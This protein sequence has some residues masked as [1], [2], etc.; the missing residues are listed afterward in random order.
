MQ[1]W[2]V[3][4]G[5]QDEGM[6]LLCARVGQTRGFNFLGFNI[7]F[8]ISYLYMLSGNISRD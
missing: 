2:A 8:L 5:S 6:D 3:G 7:S 4:R 1:E